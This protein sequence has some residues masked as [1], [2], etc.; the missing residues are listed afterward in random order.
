M[1]SKNCNVCGC[2]L[3]ENSYCPQCAAFCSQD[4][5]PQQN[6]MDA[7]QAMG[8]SEEFVSGFAEFILCAMS[9]VLPAVGAILGAIFSLDYQ[10]N[11]KRSLGSTLIHFSC[12]NFILFLILAFLA[13]FTRL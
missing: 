1:I 3:E 2:L 4:N 7:E 10:N 5:P 12:I 9:L 6:I 11:S 13:V 8:N